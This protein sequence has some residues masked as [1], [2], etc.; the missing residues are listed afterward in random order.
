MNGFLYL[1]NHLNMYTQEDTQ[2]LTLE[3]NLFYLE[4]SNENTANVVALGTTTL[5]M[6]IDVIE[7][8]LSIYDHD[9]VVNFDLLLKNG[10]DKRY[11]SAIFSQETK[12]IT[13]L[14]KEVPPKRDIEIMNTFLLENLNL[15]KERFI[16][17]NDDIYRAMI[18]MYGSHIDELKELVSNTPKH[19]SLSELKMKLDHHRNDF[20]VHP[21]E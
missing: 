13:P 11:Y 12:S 21:N 3:T 4:V 2:K 15:S 19:L 18:E 9:M 7:K 1:T 14:R 6:F 8:V 17:G 20:F 10:I 16:V 5:D